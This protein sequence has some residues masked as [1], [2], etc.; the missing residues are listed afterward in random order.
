MENKNGSALTTISVAF[1][2]LVLSVEAQESMKKAVHFL[3]HAFI[4]ID[5]IAWTSKCIRQLIYKSMNFYLKPTCMVVAVHIFSPSLCVDSVINSSL[6]SII[7]NTDDIFH[8]WWHSKLSELKSH[9]IF[10]TSQKERRTEKKFEC[11]KRKWKQMMKTEGQ[12][13]KNIRQI[14]HYFQ[15]QNRFWKLH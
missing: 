2:V 4:S 11:R 9:A 5:L 8:I 13:E 3:V 6:P 7:Q 14:V 15:D 12:R 10:Q 1:H